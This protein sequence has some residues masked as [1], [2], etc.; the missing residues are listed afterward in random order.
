MVGG[1]STVTKSES[2][3]V[4]RWATWIYRVNKD[5]YRKPLPRLLTEWSLNRM[6]EFANIHWHDYSLREKVANEQKVLPEVLLCIARADSHL[7]HALKSKNNVG[8]VGNNDRWDVVHYKTLEDGIRAM[9][10][11]ALNGTYL[12]HKR[13]IGSLSPW[14]WGDKPYYATS[15]SNWNVNVLNCLSNIHEQRINEDF[16]FRTNNLT[17]KKK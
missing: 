10:V 17:K 16:K 14:G 8:N 5:G 2:T 3:W 1:D 6:E 7:W 13:S 4:V 15:D 12:R 9:W 11:Y